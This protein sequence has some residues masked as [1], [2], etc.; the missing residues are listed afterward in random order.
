MLIFRPVLARVV[1][2][3]EVNAGLVTL[4]DLVKINALLDMKSDIEYHLA[5]RGGDKQC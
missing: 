2:M 5:R 3:A 1:S 4:A